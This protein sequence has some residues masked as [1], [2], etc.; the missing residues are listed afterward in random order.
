MILGSLKP[1]EAKERRSDKESEWKR[2]LKKDELV[3]ECAREKKSGLLRFTSLSH[4]DSHSVPVPYAL[5]L[6]S[7]VCS[8]L[9]ASLQSPTRARGRWVGSYLVVH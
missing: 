6:L 5:L 9:P 8:E 4:T 1:L 7:T 2:E 3:R